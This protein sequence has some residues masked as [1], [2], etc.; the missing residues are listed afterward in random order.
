[1]TQQQFRPGDRVMVEAQVR[2]PH[3]DDGIA[4]A[5]TGVDDAVVIAMA[6]HAAVR[7]FP[8]DAQH[9][10]DAIDVLARRCGWRNEPGYILS[11]LSAMAEALE[12]SSAPKPPT[13]REAAKAYVARMDADNLCALMA[14]LAREE[15]TTD[16]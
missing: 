15:G 16:A 3:R 8:T 6:P 10:R 1:M 4:V 9:I 5:V 12:A 14:A 11:R 7:P 13:L 2:K